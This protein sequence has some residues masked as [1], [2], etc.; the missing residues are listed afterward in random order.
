MQKQLFIII[1]HCT[2]LIINCSLVGAQSIIDSL[3]NELEIARD[4]N[5]VIILNNLAKEYREVN[6]DT[7]MKY[8][9]EGLDLG[10]EIDFHRQIAL[11]YHIIGKIYGV[12]SEYILALECYEKSLEIYKELNYKPGIAACLNSKGILYKRLRQID[13]ALNLYL[14]SLKIYDEIG[15]TSGI[16]DLSNNIG[17]I[18]QVK[19]I[20]DTALIYYNKSFSINKVLGNKS[21][22]GNYYIN[23]GEI[24]ENQGKYDSAEYFYFESLNIFRELDSKRSLINSNLYLGNYYNHISEYQKA[25]PYLEIAFNNAQEV[26]II[27]LVREAATGLSESYSQLGQDKQ[28]LFYLKL[29]DRINDSLNLTEMEK[30]I[31]LTEIYNEIE[32]ENE[33]RDLT[34]RRQKFKFI[35]SLFA[36]GL[37]ILLVFVLYRNYRIKQKANRLLAEMDQL[38]SRLFSNISHEFRTP[39]T[40]ILGPLEEMMEME[41]E[42]K[43]RRKTVKMMQRNANRLLKLVNQMLD[44]SKLDAGSMK[45]ELVEGNLIK[46]LKV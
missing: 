13:K 12:Q 19:G 46:S 2:F 18:Y 4:T 31:E 6:T 29:S 22:I 17:T 30:S 33:I 20:L 40:L 43:P 9:T 10:R 24:Y 5:K 8:A 34:I 32:R 35:F 45:L 27:E 44:L 28:E 7:A 21:L 25:V 39:L 16:V 26:G 1:I 41:K 14:K 36:L 42:K 15:D 11:S 23:I 38:K 37:T 3:K